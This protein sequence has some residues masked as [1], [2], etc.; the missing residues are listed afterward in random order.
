[1]F[2]VSINPSIR[3]K[4]VVMQQRYDNEGADKRRRSREERREGD[5]EMTERRSRERWFADCSD[6]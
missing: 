1:M 6:D 4:F 5:G 3:D 2:R